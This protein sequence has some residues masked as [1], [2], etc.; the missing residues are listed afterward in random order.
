MAAGSLLPS[1]AAHMTCVC[2]CVSVCVCVRVCRS[3]CAVC[4]CVCLSVCVSVCLCV[5]ACAFGC[6]CVP[7]R[8]AQGQHRAVMGFMGLVLHLCS[9]L[10]LEMALELESWLRLVFDRLVRAGSGSAVFQLKL[11][12]VFEVCA[13]GDSLFLISNCSTV[14]YDTFRETVVLALANLILCKVWCAVYST[15]VGSCACH[16][17]SRPGCMH[18]VFR[19]RYMP[20]HHCVVLLSRQLKFLSMQGRV[21]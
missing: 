10:A 17:S 1:L 18:A 6:V 4:V 9:S 21:L 16:L 3:V 11:A 8:S 2:V 7:V 15:V 19:F 13:V 12:I 14:Q 20:L 5:G